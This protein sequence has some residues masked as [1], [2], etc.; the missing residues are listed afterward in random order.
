MRSRFSKDPSLI[1]KLSKKRLDLS[2]SLPKE[3]VEANASSI[4][5]VI[6]SNN[7]FGKRR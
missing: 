1:G 7:S 2:F 3:D 4:L 5:P 6:H